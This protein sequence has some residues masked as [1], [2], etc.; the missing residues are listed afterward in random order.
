VEPLHPLAAAEADGLVHV[1]DAAPGIT[2]ERQGDGWLYRRQDGS[3]IDDSSERARIDAIAIPPAWTDVW[4]SPKPEGHIQATGH[5]SKGRKQYRY[6]PRFRQIRDATKYHRMSEFGETLPGLRQRIEHDLER[7]GLPREKVLG[8]ALRLMDETL[9]RIGN[10]EY[11][12]QNDSYGITTLHHEHA[13]IEGTTIQFEFRAKSGKEQRVRLS[14]PLLADILSRCEELPGQELFQ[15][16]DDSGRIVN[17]GSHDVN[18]YLH[19]VTSSI[20]TAKD[21]RTWGGSVIAAETLVDLGPPRSPTDAKKKLLAAIDAAAARL[22]NTRA[23]FRS[24][25]LHPTVPDSYLS[26]TLENAFEHA[27]SRDHLSHSES[28]VLDVVAGV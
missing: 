4:I 7:P 21:F 16:V 12:I 27:P 19:A 24:S 1:N 18:A 8:A 15:Y 20:F 23:V 3:I 11:A 6:H 13:K 17:I 26:G 10:E 22:N 5:D 25:Y 2:R 14:D 28:A 9:I